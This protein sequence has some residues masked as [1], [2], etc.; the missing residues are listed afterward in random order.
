MSTTSPLLRT[1]PSNFSRTC[2]ASVQAD[3][4]EAAEANGISRRTLFRAK[5]E[6]KILAMKDGPM[7]EGQRTWRWHLPQARETASSLLPPS[8][9]AEK[10]PH[11]NGACGQLA[12]AVPNGKAC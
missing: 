3:I 9:P 10:G 5:A 1:A 11:R 6:L 7:K 4:E 2:S 12:I 8:P